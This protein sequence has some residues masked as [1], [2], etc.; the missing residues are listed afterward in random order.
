MLDQVSRRLHVVGGR[1]QAGGAAKTGPCPP[2]SPGWGRGAAWRGVG[3]R[4]HESRAGRPP[5]GIPRKTLGPALP[6]S[7]A[8]AWRGAKHPNTARVP[9]VSD[10][11]LGPLSGTVLAAGPLGSREV[12]GGIWVGEPRPAASFALGTS[13]VPCRTRGAGRMG[14]H[15]QP[16]PGCPFSRAEGASLPEATGQVRCLQL[17]GPGPPSPQS[18]HENGYVHIITHAHRLTPIHAHQHSHR[19]TRTHTHAHTHTCAHRLTQ[20]RT[21][22]HTGS[23]AHQYSHTHTCSQ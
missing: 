12:G 13:P 11:G 23:H 17:R 3:G 8:S 1:P 22:V 9:A 6:S 4:C 5:A 2:P 10:S 18:A 7:Q 19:L 14:F 20:R 15:Q 21:H 16:W